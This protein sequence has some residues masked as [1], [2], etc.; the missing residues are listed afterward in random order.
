[1]SPK[2]GIGG[3]AKK[4]KVMCISPALPP[5]LL[6][7]MTV[8]ARSPLDVQKESPQARDARLAAE[9]LAAK[10]AEAA[11]V[12]LAAVRLR[13]AAAAEDTAACIN[14]R[15]LTADWLQRMRGAKMEVLKGEAS[16][17]ARQHD[18]E[19]DRRDRRIE[20]ARGWA[21]AREWTG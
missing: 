13:Q 3:K 20:V 17:L 10:E 16:A 19:C 18:W 8:M 9:A 11:H 21:E 5:L 1:M 14:A 2:A 6:D 15:T 12:G 7:E 4:K